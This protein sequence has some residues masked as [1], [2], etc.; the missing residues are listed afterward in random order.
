[1]APRSFGVRGGGQDAK[2]DASRRVV[3]EG[4][5]EGAARGVTRGLGQ[6]GRAHA[7]R[8]FPHLDE[9]AEDA[10]EPVFAVDRAS[11]AVTPDPLLLVLVPTRQRRRRVAVHD[12]V[13]TRS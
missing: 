4:V 1:M 5:L 6:C 9:P 11:Y 3:G 8:D 10:E 13:A 2:R 12:F 7:G